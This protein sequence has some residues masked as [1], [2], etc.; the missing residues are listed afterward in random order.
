MNVLLRGEMRE[1]YGDLLMASSSEMLGLAQLD[2]SDG[3]LNGILEFPDGDP[4]AP[5]LDRLFRANGSTAW[6]G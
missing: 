2:P 6:I 5:A 1:G 4:R 3:A